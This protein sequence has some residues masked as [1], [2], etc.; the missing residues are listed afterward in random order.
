MPNFINILKYNHTAPTVVYLFMHCYC[1]KFVIMHRNKAKEGRTNFTLHDQNFDQLLQIIANSK[2]LSGLNTNFENNCWIQHWKTIFLFVKLRRTM[3][4]I[5]WLKTDRRLFNEY[6][7]K[8]CKKK[9]K[10]NEITIKC[11]NRVTSV[12]QQQHKKKTKKK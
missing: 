7:N 11:Y 6:E 2:K 12:L 10:K 8:I 3:N 1:F 5:K 4:E 9:Q